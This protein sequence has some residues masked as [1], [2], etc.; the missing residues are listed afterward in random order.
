MEIA[1]FKRLVKTGLKKFKAILDQF[2]NGLRLF[3]F[4]ITKSSLKTLF[5]SDIIN[6]ISNNLSI[7]STE[8]TLSE[9]ESYIVSKSR[10]IYLRF[11][12]GDVYL[13]KHRSD[14]YQNSSAK[15]SI[16]MND[17]FLLSGNGVFKC[18]AIHSDLFGYEDGMVNGNHKNKDFLAYKLLQDTYVYFIG[19]KIYSPVALHFLSTINIERA[20]NFLKIL[21]QN[22]Y[23]FVGNETINPDVVSLL[24]GNKTKHIKTPP[25]NAY[26]EIDRVEDEIINYLN[27][28]NSFK[29]ICIA[30]GCSGRPLMKRLWGQSRNVFLFDFGS[31]LDGIAGN[32][33]R[34]WLRKN[35][36]NYDLLLKGLNDIE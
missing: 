8:E 14:S 24:F 31:L 1:L 19:S 29:V 3:F 5:D 16:E 28:S 30:M 34:T 17:A 33:S 20:N 9:I 27:T 7:V 12:D 26:D 11:G 13:L 32:N 4:K 2:K 36:I 21:K 35:E 18:L 25:K 10:G 6:K 15:L 23:L 22:T